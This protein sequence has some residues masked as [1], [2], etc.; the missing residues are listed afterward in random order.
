MCIGNMF[1]KFYDYII[2]SLFPTTNN[3]T[4]RSIIPMHNTDL[5]KNLVIITSTSTSASTSPVTSI[6]TSPVIIP[7]EIKEKDIE[8]KEAHKEFAILTLSSDTSQQLD[9]NNLLRAESVHKRLLSNLVVLNSIQPYQKLW[10]ENN[11]LS[12]D[13]SY[14]PRMTRYMYGQG[15]S[16]TVNFIEHLVEEAITASH[17]IPPNQDNDVY[18]MLLHTSVALDNLLITYPACEDQISRI[19][20]LLDIA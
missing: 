16:I 20:A 2:G 3:I 6:I 19:K 13:D 9:L 5:D 12:F 14:F 17:A 1:S 18:T 11:I 15:K 4:K 8:V 10:V 7:V